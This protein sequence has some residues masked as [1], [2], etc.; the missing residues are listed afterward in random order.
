MSG[1]TGTAITEKC[2]ELSKQITNLKSDL[3]YTIRLINAAV[4]EYNEKDTSIKNAI[5][6]GGV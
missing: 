2:S 4:K 6:K 1:Q 5:L 3:E